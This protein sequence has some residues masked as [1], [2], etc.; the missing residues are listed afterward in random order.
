MI[1][2]YKFNYFQMNKNKIIL[3]NQEAKLLTQSK[4]WEKL[5][6]TKNLS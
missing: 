2:L 6:K 5:P 1:N 3:L 4:I